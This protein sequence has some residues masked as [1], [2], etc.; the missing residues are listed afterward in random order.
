MRTSAPRLVAYERQRKALE[1]RKAGLTYAQI[2]EECGYS[3]PATARNAVV[4]LLAT[5]ERESVDDFRNMQFERLNYMIMKLWP[6]VQDGDEKAIMT[7]ATLMSQ[8]DKLTG[9]EAATKVDAQVHHTGG[10]LVIEGSEEEYVSAL[11]KM[12]AAA[13]ASSIQ[14]NAEVIDAEVIDAEQLELEP[15]AEDEPDVP[16]PRYVRPASQ[17][18]LGAGMCAR[19]NFLKDQHD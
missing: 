17:E 16:C 14:S 7:V 18:R 6:R 11:E 5:N 19:C 12:A 1:L 2:A 3:S 10:I 15:G 8:Q 4:K 13:G 9:T